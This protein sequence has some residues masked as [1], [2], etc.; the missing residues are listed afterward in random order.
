MIDQITTYIVSILPSLTAILAM[1]LMVVK[2][3]K[4]FKTLRDEV[5][6]SNRMKKIEEQIQIVVQENYEL[7][8]QIKLM[9]QKLDKV[10]IKDDKD[11]KDNKEVK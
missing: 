11:N 5:V 3:L 4:S 1:V 10:K 7:K 6:N 8:K 9:V 2:V